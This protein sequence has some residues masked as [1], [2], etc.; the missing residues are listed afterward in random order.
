MI[1]IMDNTFKKKFGHLSYIK[2]LGGVYDINVLNNLRYYS[3]LYFHGHTVGGT[4]PSLLEQW[5]RM[6]L[7]VHITTFTILLYLARTHIISTTLKMCS[8]LILS[9]DKINHQAMLTANAEKIRNIYSWDIITDQYL[10]HFE[11]IA[12]AIKYEKTV[13]K[14]VG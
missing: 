9:I 10:A 4:N 12:G 2:F 8:A 5:H 11:K 7:F 1:Q 3:C 14:Q 6:L 13:F